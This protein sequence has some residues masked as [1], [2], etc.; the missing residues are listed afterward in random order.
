MR[1]SEGD[2]DTRDTLG[3]DSDA[4]DGDEHILQQRPA[5]TERELVE[6]MRRNESSAFAEFMRRFRPLLLYEARRLG[7]QPALCEEF[8]DDCMADVAMRL[9]QY[10]ST[11]PRSL[12]P[13]LVRA[14]RLHRLYKRR[15]DQR[16][17]RRAGSGERTDDAFADAARAALSES[18]ARSSAGGELEELPTT[19]ALERLVGLLDQE[20]TDDERQLLSWLGSWVPQSDIAEWLG[21]SHGAARNRVMRLR[22]RLKQSAIRCAAQLSLDERRRLGRYL[23]RMFEA[24]A[25]E[26]PQLE[27]TYH[28]P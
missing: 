22:E 6:G 4:R 27:N 14:L 11:I 20:L 16:R 8:V 13:Y 2:A 18:T 5:F 10:T 19:D 24:T 3:G 21:I 7:V 17:E 25:T 23:R 1:E 15:S 9:R 28:E 26:R 12:A